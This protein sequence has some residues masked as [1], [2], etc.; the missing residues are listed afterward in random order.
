MQ[1]TET[2]KSLISL[3][4]F[5]GKVHLAYTPHG[6]VA[7]LR[8]GNGL[9]E[10]RVFNNR[11]QPIEIGLGTTSTDASTLRLGYGYGAFVGFCAKKIAHSVNKA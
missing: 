5:G 8:L 9:W 11:L 6:A 3:S 4:T 10:H 7:S 2:L 1:V